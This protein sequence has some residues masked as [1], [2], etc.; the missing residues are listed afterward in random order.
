[1]KRKPENEEKKLKTKG[2]EKPKKKYIKLNL[3]N[4]RKNMQLNIY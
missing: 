3:I 1:M 4:D 2:I